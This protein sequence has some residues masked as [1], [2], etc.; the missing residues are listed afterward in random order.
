MLI[1]TV[2]YYKDMNKTWLSNLF[3]CAWILAFILSVTGS[4]CTG[5]TR[6]KTA[7]EWEL[8]GGR[9]VALLDST[10]ASLAIIDAHTDG[11]FEQ[12]GLLDMSIQLGQLLPDTVSRDIAL[13]LYKK[14]LQEEV[15]DFSIEERLLL[16]NLLDEASLLC[17][18]ISPKLLPPRLEFIKVKGTCYGDGVFYT[19]ENRII[20]PASE[21]S[22][23][24]PEA[25][26]R[27]LLHEIFHVYSRS[28]PRQR[29]QLY[30]LIGFHPLKGTLVMNE[31]LK[32]RRL[33]NPD[34]VDCAYAI[35]L[36]TPWGQT[37][38][39]IPLI[40]TKKDNYP[41]DSLPAFRESIFFE[42]FRVEQQPD[43][44]YLVWS[45]DDGSPMFSLLDDSDLY[46]QI[47]DNTN[48]IIHPD[49]IIADNFALLA[50]S[51]SHRKNYRL[52]QYSATGQKLLRD[53]ERV[54]Q[55]TRKP[56]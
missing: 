44:T 34:G 26:L 22:N 16:R 11:F 13:G 24:D 50:L 4:W 28:H 31:N 36:R 1:S 38:E 14:K 10:D 37:I 32:R 52:N 56:R 53:V 46:R 45:R 17:H 3:F 6:D 18:A 49:E 25:L 15:A 43:S 21:L 5:C 9:Q 23:S 35:Q 48:Y 29:L 40:I 7:K 55:A 27:T 47:G 2:N 54:L 12:I 41:P 19:R 42:L 33:T 8:P 51:H 39:A 30:S 20:I